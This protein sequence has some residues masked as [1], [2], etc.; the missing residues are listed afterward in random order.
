[1][2]NYLTPFL[3]YLEAK[4]LSGPII[5]RG[6]SSDSN[7]NHLYPFVLKYP[8]SNPIMC[9][10]LVII[11]HRQSPAENPKVDIVF[12]FFCT[13]TLV[14]ETGCGLSVVAT[15]LC[16]LT[17]SLSQIHVVHVFFV[18]DTPYAA[19]EQRVMPADQHPLLW[20]ELNNCTHFPCGLGMRTIAFFCISSDN[21]VSAVDEC[22]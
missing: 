21:F 6:R 10:G 4:I 19:D 20:A 7:H 14:P 5:I 15:G 22:M 2:I 11:N 18:Y 1:M 12:C 17:F 16:E 9:N 13:P 3:M 8:A